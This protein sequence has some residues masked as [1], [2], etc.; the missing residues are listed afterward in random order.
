MGKHIISYSEIDTAKQCA[1]KHQLAYVERW[2]RPAD[3]LS[4]LGKGTAWHQVMDA[5]YTALRRTQD[6]PADVRLKAAREA[7]TEQLREMPDELA[8][9]I[10]WMYDGYAEFYRDDPHWK[11][12]GVE[13]NAVCR[14]PT[15]NGNPSSFYLKVKI[16]LVVQD[17]RTK[18]VYVVDHKSGK[19]LP[20]EKLLELDD[21]FGLYTWAMRQMGKKVFGQ[22]HNAARTYRLQNDIRNPGSTPLDERFRRTSMYRTDKELDIVARE[23]YQLAHA[24]YAQQTAV[25][26]VGAMS[27]R[28]TDPERCSWRC[29]FKEACL[30]GRKGIDI[31]GFLHDQGM[32]QNFER[33]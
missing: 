32:E 4:A 22:V 17:R 11:I 15:I 20:G 13:H 31:R 2:S 24:R 27:P 28:S 21:Q 7:A 30:A 18:N 26:R 5:H 8:D 14:L 25:T 6:E 12:L 23:T 3:P 19:D 1:L 29:D 33:H 9:L 16:D 10:Q